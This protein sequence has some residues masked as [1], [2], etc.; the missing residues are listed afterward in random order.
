MKG[1]IVY[2]SAYG[3][4]RRYAQELARRRGWPC[5]EYRQVTAKQLQEADCLIYGG[6]LYAGGVLGLRQTLRRLPDWTG[7]RL[8]VFTV[9]LSDPSQEETHRD[10]AQ[11]LRRQLPPELCREEDWFFLRGGID[12]SRLHLGHRAMMAALAAQ[13]RCRPPKARTAEDQALLDTYGGKLDFVDLDALAPLE[14]WA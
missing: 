13:L 6:G 7:K 2:G 10:I 12:Y 14:G 11:G 9:G 4:A 1:L 3:S 8:A 5:V